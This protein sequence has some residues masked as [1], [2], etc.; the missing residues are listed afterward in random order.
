MFIRET[1]TDM[2]GDLKSLSSCYGRLGANLVPRPLFG[3]AN[4][5]SGNKITLV[6]RS[7]KIE[8]VGSSFL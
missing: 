4:K 6:Q 2:F 8:L 3:Y 1:S 7:D 5:A